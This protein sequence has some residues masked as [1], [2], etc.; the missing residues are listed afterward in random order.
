MIV[1]GI[2]TS[3][4]ETAASIIK[5]ERGK[6]KI[7]SHII[8]SQIKTHSL[9]GGVVPEVAARQ[10]VLNIVPVIDVAL[11][12]AK[13]KPAKI[14]VISVT[15]GP[16][17]ITSLRVGTQAAK[18]L[19]YLWDKK[20]VGLNHMEGHIYAN[21]YNNPQI[22]FPVLCLVVS[23]GHTE[24]ILMKK[25]NNYKLIGR[26][27]DDAAGEA[28]DK[29][30]KL[31]SLGYPGGP[32]VQAMAEKGNP[33]AFD[34]PRPMINY[35][36]FDF[37]FSGLKTSVLYLLKKEFN[38]KKAPVADIC[39]S[40]QQAV[41]DVLISKTLAAAK[42]FRV[43][44]VLLAGGVAANGPLREKLGEEIKNNLPGVGYYFPPLKLCT[45]NAAMIAIAG[46]FQAQKKN[47]TTWKKLE[48]DPNWELI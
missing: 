45:D 32:K 30:A 9:Y 46:Y 1:L 23:G 17:L 19:A 15:R 20:L 40:F 13:I 27:R 25:H 41:T 16:G 35:K 24:L 38:N 5:G 44:N 18:T 2:E 39:A 28:F 7:L 12:Q 36:N 21:W 37:S 6:I 14:D 29:V 48:P 11:R 42:T 43:K 22:K 47:F 10:H 26:T 31:L 34:F 3:C 4:D 33:T 8:A